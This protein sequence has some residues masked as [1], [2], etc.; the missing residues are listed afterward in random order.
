[1]DG[2]PT[3]LVQLPD[4]QGVV[5]RDDGELVVTHDVAD[6]RG[7]PLQPGDRFRPVMAWL[8]DERCLVGGVLPPGAVSAEVVDLRGARVAAGVGGGA[9]AAIIE[10]ANDGREAPVCCR[11]AGGDPVRRP[12]PNAYPCTP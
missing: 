3:V 9:Y 5:R 4:G 1:M 6:D 10:Q 2:V 7:Q 8:D 11:D 12:L